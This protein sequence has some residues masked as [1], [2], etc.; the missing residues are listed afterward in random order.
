MTH[1]NEK[2]ETLMTLME[3]ETIDVLWNHINNHLDEGSLE[4]V[5][6]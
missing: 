3:Y 4:K 6:T 1:M 5:M 2:I